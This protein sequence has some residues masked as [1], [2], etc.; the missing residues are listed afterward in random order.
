MSTNQN[1]NSLPMGKPAPSVPTFACLVYLSQD[2]SGKS[3]ARVANLGGLQATGASPRDAMMRVCRE[4]K[5]IVRTAHAAGETIDWIDPP[6]EPAPGEQ[7]RSIPVH[8]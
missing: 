3:I 7:V 6:V 8:L 4:F 2:E 5:E 1:D